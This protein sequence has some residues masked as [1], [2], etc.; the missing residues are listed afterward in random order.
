VTTILY[1]PTAP[2][3]VS[4]DFDAMT[5]TMTHPTPLFD[6]F[7][8]K[9][10]AEGITLNDGQRRFAESLLT[11]DATRHFMFGGLGSGRTFVT[12]AVERFCDEL[13]ADG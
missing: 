4:F 8:R 5:A 13:K 3:R 2:L 12:A 7:L 6:Q 10:E 1:D 9:C 11:N